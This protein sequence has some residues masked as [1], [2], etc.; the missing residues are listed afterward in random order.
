MAIPDPDEDRRAKR[1]AEAQIREYVSM[2][3]PLDSS[4]L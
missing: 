4:F 2:R 3:A 1:D